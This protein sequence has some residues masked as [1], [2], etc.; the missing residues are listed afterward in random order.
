MSFFVYFKRFGESTDNTTELHITYID[1]SNDYV[2]SYGE[3][4]TFLA[5][6]SY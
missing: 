1:G 5:L 4:I 3:I 6:L 2:I